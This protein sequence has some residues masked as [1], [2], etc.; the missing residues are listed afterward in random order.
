MEVHARHIARKIDALFTLNADERAALNQLPYKVRRYKKGE[1]IINEGDVS[2]SSFV[3]LEGVTSMI[4]MCGAG[5]RQ[6][7]MFHF[8]GD[9]PDLH[10][11]YIHKADSTLAPLRRCAIAF[12]PHAA[13]LHLCDTFPRIKD[14][15]WRATLVDAAILREWLLNIGQRPA[16]KRIA[17]FLCEMV[18]RM[19]LSG[20]GT[21]SSSVIPLTQE[22]IG[23]CLGLGSIHVNR[24]LQSLRHAG[25]IRLNRTAL[26]I[27]DWRALQDAGDFDVGYLHL[28]KRQRALLA[29]LNEDNQND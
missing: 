1:V 19:Q 9:M 20:M 11:L 26:E 22:E 6:L 14:A 3:V 12:I 29:G 27:P 28:S 5:D 21:T 23:D 8:V 17:H 4:K 10:S 18:V 15:F 25:L 2:T 13:I 16:R 24:T 7:V